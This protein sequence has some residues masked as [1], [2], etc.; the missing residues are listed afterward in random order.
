MRASRFMFPIRGRTDYPL[1]FDR[2]G[3]PK[4]AFFAL[5]ALGKNKSAAK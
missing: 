2:Q 1:V 4:P 5:I 3:K